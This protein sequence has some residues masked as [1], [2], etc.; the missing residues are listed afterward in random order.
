MW[1]NSVHASGV[2]LV[3]CQAT[4]ALIA[5]VRPLV[6][7]GVVD[8]DGVVWTLNIGLLITVRGGLGVVPGTLL[9]FLK[10]C[11]VSSTCTMRC[12]IS[13]N[14]MLGVHWAIAPFNTLYF[15]P[16]SYASSTIPFAPL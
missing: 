4:S 14:V 2:N 9:R 16:L 11:C 12:W 13:A 15:K 6:G 5:G 10:R 7:A 3:Y 8:V 1:D